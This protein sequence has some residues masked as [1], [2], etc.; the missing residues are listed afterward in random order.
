MCVCDNDSIGDEKVV[1]ST[2]GPYFLDKTAFLDMALYR[3]DKWSA[4]IHAWTTVGGRE[5]MPLLV[6]KAKINYCPWCGRRLS[7][8]D[9]GRE[10]T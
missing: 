8:G 7:L 10:D 6:V 3:K 9:A 4:E 5:P 1:A 2:E